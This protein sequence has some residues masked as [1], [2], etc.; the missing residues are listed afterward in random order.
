MFVVLPPTLYRRWFFGPWQ[1][2]LHNVLSN[3]CLQCSFF[4]HKTCRRNN[5][6]LIF[7]LASKE[8]PK[9]YTSCQQSINCSC[10]QALCNLRLPRSIKWLGPQRFLQL[11]FC[12]KFRE[13]YIS[14]CRKNRQR[15]RCWQ[16][17]QSLLDLDC[18]TV[19]IRNGLMPEQYKFKRCNTF[20][21]WI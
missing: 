19:N 15:A 7:P 6:A 21:K 18:K 8:N 3:H 10:A 9:I 1:W 13:A 12:G 5:M 2:F 20:T 11:D 4:H 17:E 14:V 16:E